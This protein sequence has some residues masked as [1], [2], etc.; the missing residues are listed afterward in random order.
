LSALLQRFLPVQPQIRPFT[1]KNTKGQ[2]EA[3]F[4]VTAM[5]AIE[6]F[7]AGAATGISLMTTGIKTN[8]R[9]RK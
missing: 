3:M 1:A 2:V 6:S 5:C 8:R 9:R 4:L 7:L